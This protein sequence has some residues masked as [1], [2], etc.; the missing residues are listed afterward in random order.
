MPSKKQYLLLVDD[1]RNILNALSRELHDWA[2]EREIEVITAMSAKDGLLILKEHGGET[3]IAVSDLKMP[4]MKGSDFLLEVKNTYPEIVLILLTGY[5]EAEEVVKAVKA[6][7]FSYMLKPWDS[8]YLIHEIQ[9]A[10]EYGETRRQNEKYRKTIEEELKWAGEMQKTILKPSLPRSDGVEF[11]VSYRPVPGIYCGGDY[12]DVIFL[13]PD[14]YLLLVGDV[15]GHGVKAAFVTGILKAVIYPEYVRNQIGRDLSPSAFLSWFNDRM[16]A[17][18]RR[19]SDMIIT[20]F[21]GILDLKTSVFRYSNAGHN[22]PLLIRSGNP[23]VLPVSGSGIG[24]AQSSSY[25]EQIV[26]IFPDDVLFL[27]TDG[28]VEIGDGDGYIQITLP[29]ILER[30]EYGADYHR[31]ILNAILSEAKSADFTDDVTLLTARISRSE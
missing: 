29:S 5:S 20:F 4:E 24:F 13:G 3:V 12:Y 25:P 23:I 28:L 31:R 10:Y 9:K 15:A 16:N 2:E 19:T 18:F 1:E 11:R 30:E 6:G 22:H 8:D 17:E 27:Y 14:R 26:D 21:A 7:I